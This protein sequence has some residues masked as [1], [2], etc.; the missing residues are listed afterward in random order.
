M[1]LFLQHL[2]LVTSKDEREA[3]LVLLTGGNV[4]QAEESYFRGNKPLHAIMLHINEHNW[5][6]FVI[7]N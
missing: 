4:Q 3:E 6:R 7:E 5:D 2:R 1:I